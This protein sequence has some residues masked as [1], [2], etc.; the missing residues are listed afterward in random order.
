VVVA[1]GLLDPPSTDKGDPVSRAA[2]T[3]P[4]RRRELHEV[5]IPPN[6]KPLLEPGSRAY[7]MGR[8]RIIVSQ[9]KAGWHL[10]ISKPDHLPS[11]EEVR[12][13]RYALVP[14]EATMAL[15]LPPKG[16]YVNVH[17]YC[18]QMYEIPAEYIEQ[19]QDRL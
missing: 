12:D 8:C 13:A 10:S 1:S 18:L 17:E 16:E 19:K 2:L 3:N 11:W 14:D 9:Q 4:D 15:L 7:L 6:V 5:E